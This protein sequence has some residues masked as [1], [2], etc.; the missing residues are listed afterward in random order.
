[1]STP[2]GSRPKANGRAGG[3]RDSSWNSPAGFECCGLECLPNVIEG[4]QDVGSRVHRGRRE[5]LG[6]STPQNELA[7]VWRTEV[8]C[9]VWVIND[10][11]AVREANPVGDDM[12]DENFVEH[13]TGRFGI[14]AEDR[15]V[16]K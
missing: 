11:P 13:G 2:R 1:M 3:R 15:R 14:R 4:Y 8:D 16:G 12:F 10:E 5:F 7:G 9:A 6:L